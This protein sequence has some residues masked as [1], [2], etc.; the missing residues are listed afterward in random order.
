MKKAIVGVSDHCGWAVL[1]TARADGT[2]LDRRRVELID[3]GLPNMPHH[4]GAPG[5]PGVALVKRVA[6]S[7]EGCARQELGKLEGPIGG[8]ALRAYPRLPETIEERISD[9]RANTMADGV[10]YREALRRAAEALGWRVH[11]FEAKQVLARNGPVIAKAGKALGSPWN[12][13]HR[14]ALAAALAAAE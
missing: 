11:W 9:Y 12:Q 6:K 13:D 10:M 3:A 2:V 1:V 7:A 4:H 14:L 8:I 5:L